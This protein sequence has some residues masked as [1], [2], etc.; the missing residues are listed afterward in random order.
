MNATQAGTF[1][2]QDREG[3]LLLKT[4]EGKTVPFVGRFAHFQQLVIQPTT[5]F[6]G[7]VQLVNLLLGW[8]QTVLKCF[9]H[10]RIV[11][12]T[13]QECKRETAPHLPQ[14]RNAAFIPMD[15]SQGMKAAVVGK[16]LW[17]EDMRWR[18]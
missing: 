16:S 2:F 10:S 3:V 17:L 11:V 9:Q 6:K 15:K 13:E 7:L 5:L 14:T 1:L 18:F 12:Q 4:G 8:E